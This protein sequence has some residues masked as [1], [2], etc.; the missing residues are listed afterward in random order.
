MASRERLRTHCRSG[1]GGVNSPA[2]GSCL[3]G[4]WLCAS[5]TTS[6]SFC[7]IPR[8]KPRLEKGL[9]GPFFVSEPRQNRSSL[10]NLEA[11]RGELSAKVKK[12]ETL[13]APVIRA[14]LC[15]LGIEYRSQGN[16]SVVRVYIEH[17]DGITVDDCEQ[18]SRQVSGVLDVEDPIGTRYTL[19][20]S[21]PGIDRPLFHREQYRNSSGRY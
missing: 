4:S 1:P 9:E 21:S 19:E 7:G 18:V 6:F 17:A 5:G 8:E 16:H 20:V 11:G 12:L 14:G 13:L 15:L 2:R 3:T 10:K